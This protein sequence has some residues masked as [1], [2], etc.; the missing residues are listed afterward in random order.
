MNTKSYN[1]YEE[2]VFLCKLEYYHIFMNIKITFLFSMNLQMRVY[3]N[4]FVILISE[5][6]VTI[7]NNVKM[8][9][10]S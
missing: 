6:D 1:Y 8:K 10:R 4:N 2:L 9:V 5:N 3:Y 7:V